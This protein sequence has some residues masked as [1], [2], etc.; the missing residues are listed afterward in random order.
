MA[1]LA[2]QTN[3]E[4]DTGSEMELRG[5]DGA[6]LFNDD[7]SAM[8]ITLLGEDS[9]IAVKARNNQTDR[10]IQQGPRVKLT[11]AGLTSDN[12]SYLA[13]LTTGWNITMGGEKA[14]FTPQAALALYANPK[15]SFVREQVTAFIED[16]TNF[17]RA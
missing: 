2:N 10:R 4:P 9:D 1:D 11:A 17:L 15:L 14:E 13:K 3:Y 8:T 6:Q 7:G 5:I 16:R 12:A